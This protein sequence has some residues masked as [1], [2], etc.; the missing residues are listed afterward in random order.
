MAA[1]GLKAC[2]GFRDDKD[3]AWPPVTGFVLNC[4]LTW[5]HLLSY[6]SEETLEGQRLM[7]VSAQHCKTFLLNSWTS[8]LERDFEEAWK[9]SDL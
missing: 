8:A 7:T 4:E 3:K 5:S 1:K 9:D 6:H 2:D